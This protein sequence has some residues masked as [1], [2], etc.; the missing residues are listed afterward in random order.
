MALRFDALFITPEAELPKKVSEGLWP[1]IQFVAADRVSSIADAFQKLVDHSY[2]ICF[3]APSFTE[4]IDT[5]FK[6]MKTVG[7]DETC[8]FFQLE[9]GY[10]PSGEIPKLI[11]GAIA[12]LVS[13]APTAA[14]REVLVELLQVEFHRAEVTRRVSDVKDAVSLLVREIDLMARD[15]Q[16]GRSR[17]YDTA[18]KSF[19]ELHLAFDKEVFSQYIEALTTLASAAPAFDVNAVEIPDEILEKRLPSLTKDTYRGPSARVWNKLLRKFG[20]RVESKLR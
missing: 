4:G 5:F 12:G 7:R 20:Q 15:R 10:D 6:D 16:R 19:V 2:S 18:V 13:A 17:R 9:Q 14:E 8:F 3:I 11:H 1:E